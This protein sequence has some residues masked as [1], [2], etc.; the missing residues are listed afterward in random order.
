MA[1]CSKEELVHQ[2]CELVWGEN[3]KVFPARKGFD[4]LSLS[5]N[6]TLNP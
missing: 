5:Q 1:Q 4:R 2:T 6:T 3:G